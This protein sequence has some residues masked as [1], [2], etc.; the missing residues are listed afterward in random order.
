MSDLPSA[1]WDASRSAAGNRSPWLIAA[2]VS[3]ATFMEVLDGSIV[4]VALR[5]IA[6]DLGAGV[7]ESTWV[8]T[9][10]LVASAVIIPISGWLSEVVGRKAYYM[11]CVAVFTISSVLCGIAGSLTA[12][13]FFRILQGLGGGG[14]APSEQS[15]IADTFSPAKRAGAFAIYGI[16][17]VVAPTV[18][19]TLGGWITDHFSWHWIF[20]INI[21]VGIL[22]LT[23]VHY[24]VVDPPAVQKDKA[25]RRAKGF[26]VDW[27]GFVLVALFLGCLEVV[28]DKGQELDW[29]QSNFIVTFAAI[30]TIA[31]VL[32]VPWEMTRK[33]PIVNVHLLFQR[34]FGSTFLVML[35]VGAILF[36]STQ[37]MPQLLQSSYSY[38]STISGFALLPGGVALLM[39]MPMSARL[40]RFVQPKYLLAFGFGA[41][42]LGMWHSSS[43]E[44]GADFGFFAWARVTQVV[45][46]AFLFI[47]IST[48]AYS[49]IA[50]ELSAQASS[51]INVARNLGGSIGVSVANAVLAQ[52]EQF[53][54]SRIVETTAPSSID[55][56]HTFR[57]AVDY[58]VAHGSSLVHAQQQAV[59]WIGQSVA[60]QST[61]LSYIDVYRCYALF[62]LLMIP[63]VLTL[64]R[65]NLTDAKVG[66]H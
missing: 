33:D 7:S 66:G 18:G 52:R 56:Q 46:L 53:H 10:Y 27:I 4:N 13:I 65:I 22:S 19:P 45:G 24:L 35:A 37:V 6:G 47:P 60:F 48:A 63:L 41:V 5:Q 21:P 50:P 36:G 15:I 58:F 39:M 43:L 34:H 40:S 1:T 30:S 3:L 14:M 44:P 31:F 57:Q 26:Q 8:V 55:Y 25:T 20:F 29:L 51:L 9:T 59:A 23:L 11:L 28:L 49:G 32:F 38:T 2:V 64:K 42:A 54:Q 17:V 16:S 12:L 62:A 61:L